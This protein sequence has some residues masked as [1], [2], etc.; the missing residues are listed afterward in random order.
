MC[1]GPPKKLLVFSVFAHEAPTMW[2]GQK[3]MASQE[4]FF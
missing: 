3:P 2:V 1:A 4:R